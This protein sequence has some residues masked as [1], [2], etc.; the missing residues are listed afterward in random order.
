MNL[1]FSFMELPPW[2]QELAL[3]LT[4]CA[5]GIV[6]LVSLVAMVSIWGERKVAGRIQSRH[7]PMR[8]GGWHG[9]A[10]SLA[11]GIKLMAKEDLLP[12]GADGFLFRLAPYLA[13]APALAA[14]LML[15]WSIDLSGLTSGINVGVFFLLAIMGIEVL[16]VIL[17]GWSSNNKWS[18]YGAMREACQMVSYEIPLGLSIICAI[19]VAGS[20][21]MY[22]ISLRQGS[23]LFSW[24]IFHDPFN[25]AAFILYYVAGLASCKRAPFDLP[26]SESELV[27]GFHTEYSGIRFSFFFFAEYAAMFV[28]CC[29]QTTLWL[30]AW[31][32]PFGLVAHF[33]KFRFL[34]DGG[35]DW[36]NM[37]L[38]NGLGAT[39]FLLKA[40]L[41]VFAQMWLRWTLPR[42]R[43]DQVLHLCV[44]VMLPLAAVNVLCAAAYLFLTDPKKSVDPAH[45]E[46][47]VISQAMVNVQLGMQ[48]TLGCIGI[49]L[50]GGVMAIVFWAYM[51]RQRS[52]FKVMSS[53]VDRLP[54]LPGA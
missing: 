3:K 49:A 28:V 40:S 16:G 48:I 24:L 4:V 17:A 46:K 20:L 32:D 31:Y 8:V 23:G 30:G 53:Q 50:V 11:D 10:Q 34:A 1:A 13:F 25:F 44:K 43:I 21:N 27:A 6:P 5:A 7:G 37:I 18:V 29:I 19:I 54:T 38:A 36:K 52:T 35:V 12:K 39:C 42:L 15:A 2:L 51:H 47:F 26:E 22:E 9:W 33:E 45:P 41:L 14:F